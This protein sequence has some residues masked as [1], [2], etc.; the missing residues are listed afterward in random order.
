ML[1]VL[2]RFD[3]QRDG[4]GEQQH[5]SHRVVDQLVDRFGDDAAG[6]ERKQARYQQA[7]RADQETGG[8][9]QEEQHLRVR[10]VRIVGEVPGHHAH[11]DGAE[12]QFGE[13][14]QARNR[15]QVA[16]VDDQRGRRVRRG[17]RPRDLNVV[18]HSSDC[19]IAN[20]SRLKNICR[21]EGIVIK[22]ECPCF[23]HKICIFVSKN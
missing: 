1:A 21:L 20:V 5:H 16:R 15:F 22:S 18:R 14:Q 11:A 9:Q 13:L 23:T 10:V 6:A 17:D 12:N 3:Q 2:V 7:E 4:G 8:H 19:W